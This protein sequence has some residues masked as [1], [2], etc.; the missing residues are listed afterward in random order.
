MYLHFNYHEATLKAHFPPVLGEIETKLQSGNKISKIFYF[1]NDSPIFDS[2][3]NRGFLSDIKSINLL[4]GTNNS[5]KS[6]FLRA[7]FKLDIEVSSDNSSIYELLDIIEHDP[8]LQNRVISDKLIA[9]N[10]QVQVLGGLLNN[11][12]LIEKT[13]DEI[14]ILKKA[15]TK[16]GIL[17]KRIGLET[18]NLYD[19][20][21]ELID[22]IL[23][24][25]EKVKFSALNKLEDKLY[26]PVFRT[27]ISDNALHIES[28]ESLIK[29]KFS[30]DNKV[31]TGLNFFDQIYELHTSVRIREL[32]AF[33]SWIKRNFY[34]EQDIEIIPDKKSLNV[35]LDIDGQLR[36]VYDLGDGIQQLILLM[37]PIYTA[38]QGTWFFIEEPETHLHPG[39]Q[40]IFIEA[41]L[42]DNYIKEKQ[43]RFFFTTHSNHFL[44]ISINHDE[45]SIFQFEKESS[46]KF[47]IK[48][49]VKPDK[50]LLQILGINS[51]SVFLA[52]ASI[53]VEGPTDRKYISKWLRLYCE[54]KDLPYLK[55][56]IDFAFFEYGGN[57][58]EHYLFDNDFEEDLTEKQVREKI[59]AFSHSNK[60]YLL[61]DNDNAKDES[62]KGKRRKKLED[63]S[64][65]YFKYQNTEFREIENLLPVKIIREFLSELAIRSDED[66]TSIEFQRKDYYA[67]GLGDFI[68]LLFN[69]RNIEGKKFRAKSGTLNNLYKNRLSDLVVKS[70]YTYV[71][72]IDENDQLDKLITSLYEFIK[73][74]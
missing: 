29:N 42:T 43:L 60:I 6:R 34:P 30:I 19:N 27:I 47:N 21:I 71:D 41:L 52:N 59:D 2:G 17:N 44:D 66:L 46:E 70:N 65:Q 40:R 3:L 23:F 33:T 54:F 1:L 9:I 5:G 69:K 56:D 73:F 53:W 24:F 55:E 22:K 62:A 11:S 13:H 36:P 64:S 35:Y 67:I 50:D 14:I 8:I 31:Y 74:K 68:E 39:L 12:H 49:N 45:I 32:K 37:F 26:V 15:Y 61:A 63:I 48:T 28:Y 20:V 57:L 72:L 58:I 38:K 16:E 4:V 51:S 10:K 25:L 18:G 7:L